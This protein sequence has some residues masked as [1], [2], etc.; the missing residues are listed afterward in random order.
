MASTSFSL[1]ILSVTASLLESEERQQLIRPSTLDTTDTVTIFIYISDAIP[2]Y[3]TALHVW[4]MPERLPDAAIKTTMEKVSVS[5]RVFGSCGRGFDRQ[6]I[7]GQINH[8]D[9]ERTNNWVQG[10]GVITRPLAETFREWSEVLLLLLALDNDRNKG[11]LL[12]K[13]VV[14]GGSSDMGKRRFTSSRAFDAADTLTTPAPANFSAVF[15]P[16]PTYPGTGSTL[17]IRISKLT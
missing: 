14:G 17:S 5:Q 10:L 9:W 12:E 4:I 13:P 3:S 1:P 7:M 15:A 8:D 16:F 11:S 2:K 6:S